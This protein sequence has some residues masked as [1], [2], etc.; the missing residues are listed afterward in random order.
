MRSDAVRSR[1]AWNKSRSELIK[2]RLEAILQEADILFARKGYNATSLDDIAG[3]LH[4]TKTALYHYVQDKNELLYLC[5]QRSI[6]LT[7]QCYE[8][9]DHQGRTGLEKLL[10]YLRID[11]TSG[12]MRSSAGS[13]SARLVSGIAAIASAAPLYQS[14]WKI[15]VGSSNT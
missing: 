10:A 12:V 1:T 2:I 13:I 5:Y 14:F 6:E 4:I 8:Q 9:A 7:E 3:R 11:A 15:S